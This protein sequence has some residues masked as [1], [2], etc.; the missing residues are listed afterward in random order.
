MISNELE[1]FET[2]QA[3]LLSVPFLEPD[4]SEYQ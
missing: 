1:M 2:S 3:Y 4:A